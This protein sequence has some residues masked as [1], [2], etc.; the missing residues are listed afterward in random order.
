MKPLRLLIA[1]VILAALGGAIWYSQKN[2]PKPEAVTET[3]TVKVL[4]LKED[5]IQKVRV[6]HANGETLELKRGDNG[7]WQM[8]EPAPYRVDESNANALVSSLSSLDADQVVNANNTDWQSYG[9]DPGKFTVIVSTKDSKEYKLTIGDEAP[10][11]S[12]IYARLSG[13]N[14][15]FGTSS[16]VKS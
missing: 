15:L 4:S 13:D 9:L 10:A 8:T 5:Q 3:K 7:K 16:N 12:V 11:S 14:R 2:P 6:V 1:V